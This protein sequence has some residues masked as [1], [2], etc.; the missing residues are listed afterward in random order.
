MELIRRNRSVTLKFRR[1][2][3]YLHALKPRRDSDGCPMRELEYDLHLG[4]LMVLGTLTFSEVKPRL[5][6]R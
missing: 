3:I 2:H 6:R 1:S 5:G 4:N